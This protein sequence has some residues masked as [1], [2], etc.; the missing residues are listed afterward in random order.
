MFPFAMSEIIAR[1][2]LVARNNE[3]AKSVDLPTVPA[4]PAT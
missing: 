2:F 3:T 1:I 4:L